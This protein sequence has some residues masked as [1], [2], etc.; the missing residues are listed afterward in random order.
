MPGA[1]APVYELE[2]TAWDLDSIQPKLDEPGRDDQPLARAGR[3]V[4]A[5]PEELRWA[6]DDFA[7][8]E[9]PTVH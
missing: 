5:R 6:A 4:A 3:P 1:S 2:L 8:A 9:Y 7:P